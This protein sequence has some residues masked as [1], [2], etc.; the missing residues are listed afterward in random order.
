[1]PLFDDVFKRSMVIPDDGMSN[2]PED[3]GHGLSDDLW[4]ARLLR[5]GV[6]EIAAMYRAYFE[7]GADVA[8]A[9]Y[10]ARMLQDQM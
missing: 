10:R 6:A 5:G 2:A 3:R 7:A 1:M 8:T 9:S 4:T